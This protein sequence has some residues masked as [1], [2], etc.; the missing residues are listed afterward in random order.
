L[1][2]WKQNFPSNPLGKLIWLF[3]HVLFQCPFCLKYTHTITQSITQS[4]NHTQHTQHNTT[5]HT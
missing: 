4:H 2:Y 5:Q 3:Q 1:V